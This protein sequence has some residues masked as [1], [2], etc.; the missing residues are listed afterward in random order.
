MEGYIRCSELV[1]QL[2]QIQEGNVVYVVSGVLELAK[3]A[4]EHGE[5]FDR[6]LFLDSLQKKVGKTG[7]LLIPTFN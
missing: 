1:G 2:D 5:R 7:T 6:D 4:R 3:Q